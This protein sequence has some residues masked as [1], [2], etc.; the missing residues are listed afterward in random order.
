MFGIML[1]AELEFGKIPMM[2]RTRGSIRRVVTA[3][4]VHAESIS[5]MASGFAITSAGYAAY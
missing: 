4:A 3:V 2:P 5:R 1:A